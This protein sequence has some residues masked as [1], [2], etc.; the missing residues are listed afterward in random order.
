MEI[1]AGV[2]V[3][4]AFEDHAV[5]LGG[6]DRLRM[7]VLDRD[8]VVSAG[9]FFQVNSAV[10]GE[11]VAHVLK[12]L[13]ANAWTVLDLYCGAGLERRAL[14]AIVALQPRSVIYVS[15]DPSTLA[16]DA[17]RFISGGYRLTE[18]TPFD[19]FPQ[20]YHVESISLFMK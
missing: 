9:S 8:F 18:V 1:E 5:V 16:R 19:L 11:M 20:T 10:A 15:C 2:S 17:A 14:D 13:S 6:D 12:H 7:R 3:V 4:H